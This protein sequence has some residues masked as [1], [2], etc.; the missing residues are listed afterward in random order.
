MDARL[1]EHSGE[2]SGREWNFDRAVLPLTEEHDKTV[3]SVYFMA[4]GHI[5]YRLTIWHQR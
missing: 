5:S 3:R 4:I 2:N 1:D